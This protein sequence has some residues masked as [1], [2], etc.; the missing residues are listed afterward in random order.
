M[1]KILRVSKIWIG[2]IA[3][4]PKEYIWWADTLLDPTGNTVL[5]FQ[6]SVQ[7]NHRPVWV[8][9]DGISPDTGSMYPQSDSLEY[10]QAMER[11][12]KIGRL[13]ID[14]TKPSCREFDYWVNLNK[15]PKYRIVEK[16]DC[17][18]SSSGLKFITFKDP[19][20]E[21]MCVAIWGY[22]GKITYDQAANVVDVYS[23]FNSDSKII[24]FDEFQYFTG[25]EKIADK[26]FYGTVNLKSIILPSTT[27]E[28][29]QEAFYYS[30]IVS[31]E[32]PAGVTTINP[33]A[34]IGCGNLEKIIVRSESIPQ[35]GYSA[36]DN[37]HPN[38]SIYVLDS[39]LP[40]YITHV[41]WKNYA[42][43][44]KPISTL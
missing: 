1:D 38:A 8:T 9:V 12:P 18:I 11:L 20:A 24:Y 25:V 10:K 15:D 4:N 43:M 40:S 27:T 29:G 32:I 6:P 35:L 28:I 22:K 7:F 44:L 21:L 33:K 42:S 14:K 36:F 34:F 23:V 19:Q 3:P 5:T 39:L 26:A 41:S 31:I 16:L 37:I 2:P 13:W 17:N 30:G